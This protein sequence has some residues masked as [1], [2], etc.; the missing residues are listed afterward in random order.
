MRKWAEKAVFR[1]EAMMGAQVVQVVVKFAHSYSKEAHALLAEASLAPTLWHCA[2]EEDVNMWVVVMDY[3]QGATGW[4]QL[5]LE[6]GESLREAVR[7][8]HAQDMVFGDLR[9]PNVLVLEKKAMVVDF[10]WAGREGSARYP[11]DI[12]LDAEDGLGWHEGVSREG[13]IEKAHDL[14]MLERVISGKV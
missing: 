2:Y 6:Q 9:A 13:L 11:N 7:I 8:L 14:Y 5:S 4:T 10:D 1:A 3:V 12:S